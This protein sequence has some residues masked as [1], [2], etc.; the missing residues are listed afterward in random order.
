MNNFIL[1]SLIFVLLNSNTQATDTYLAFRAKNTAPAR[2]TD[3]IE[4]QI[5]YVDN[6]RFVLSEKSY[7]NSI[8]DFYIHE[9]LH[10]LQSLPVDGFE[11]VGFGEDTVVR[12]Q[13]KLLLGKKL[14]PEKIEQI[15]NLNSQIVFNGIDLKNNLDIILIY[16]SENGAILGSMGHYSIEPSSKTLDGTAEANIYAQRAFY[17]G[18]SGQKMG[19]R[20]TFVGKMFINIHG[21]GEHLEIAGAYWIE[22][23]SG[24][25]ILKNER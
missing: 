11:Y 17:D 3:A 8:K 23:Q 7:F 1:F 6:G 15:K 14:T 5:Y 2:F 4:K 18:P 13:G 24:L 20:K 21:E 19:T 9:P 16:H 10:S 22:S 12:D 25:V